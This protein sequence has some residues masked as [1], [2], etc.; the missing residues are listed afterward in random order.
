MQNA[1][2]LRL[3]TNA[4]VHGST[5]PLLASQVPFGCLHGLMPEKELSLLQFPAGCM[6]QFRARAPQI[7]RRQLGKADLSRALLYD[8]ADEPF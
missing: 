5:N 6:A 2:N 8:M 1:T 7:V 4:V 3:T